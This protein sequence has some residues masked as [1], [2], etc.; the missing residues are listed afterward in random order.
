MTFEA[1]FHRSRVELFTVMEDH[2]I[3]NMQNQG[4][5]IGVFIARDKLGH[6][7]QLLGDVEQFVAQP[8]EHDTPDKGAGQRWVQDI[9]IL[10]KRDAQGL[11]W[12]LGQGRKGRC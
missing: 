7:L 3:A 4:L 5:G 12:L 8:G 9:G 1:V 2:A 11:G 6:D 10:S